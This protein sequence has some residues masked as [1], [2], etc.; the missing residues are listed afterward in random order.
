MNKILTFLFLIT[1]LPALAQ[2]N[3]KLKGLIKNADSVILVS[4]HCS[5]PNA[6]VRIDGQPSPT[7]IE[8]LDLVTFNNK[9]DYRAIVEKKV[10]TVMDREQLAGMVS[11]LK[12]GLDPGRKCIPS[13][14]HT[15][16]IFNN[17][18]PSW[19]Q[20][21]FHCFQAATSRNLSWGYDDHVLLKLWGLFKSKGI[22]YELPNE[23]YVKRFF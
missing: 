5:E 22:I 9:L 8:Q 15:I 20:I 11:K 18:T 4:N 14:R 6:V 12:P 1:A 16:L 13:Y 17:G 10:L 23:A 19:I 3:T 2:V 21:C 7:E